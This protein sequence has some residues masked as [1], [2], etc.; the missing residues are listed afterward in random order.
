MALSYHHHHDR[1]NHYHIISYHYHL[2]PDLLYDV[3][4]EVLGGECLHVGE[5]PLLLVD[6]VLA[7]AQLAEVL[8]HLD[9]QE[10][11]DEE[12]GSGDEGG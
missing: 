11:E 10:D 7:G 12:A 4:P 8:D 2:P 5:L 1:N 9:I 6:R 3:A